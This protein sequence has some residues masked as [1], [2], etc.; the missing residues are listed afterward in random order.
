MRART[1]KLLVLR[2]WGC[3]A[4]REHHHGKVGSQLVNFSI[5]TTQTERPLYNAPG[6]SSAQA[7]RQLFTHIVMTS[8]VTSDNYINICLGNTSMGELDS[9]VCSNWIVEMLY[10][11]K[12]HVL[13]FGKISVNVDKLSQRS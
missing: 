6:R 13:Q 4:F 12:P 1:D 3:H 8:P 7:Y 11:S 5:E 9:A 10:F 2:T